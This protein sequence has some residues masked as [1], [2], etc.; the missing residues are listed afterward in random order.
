MEHINKVT[1]VSLKELL[2]ND[3]KVVLSCSNPNISEEV[4]TK[5]INSKKFLGWVERLDLKNHTLK[6]IDIRDVY[7][8]GQ[9]V[10]FICVD[11]V[12]YPIKVPEGHTPQKLPGYVFIRGDAVAVLVIVIEK[13]TNKRYVLLVNQY[14]LPFGTYLKEFP[15]GMM[16]ENKNFKGQAALELK[17]EAGIEIKPEDLKELLTMGPSLGGCD[18]TVK[19]FYCEIYK[20]QEEI[21]QIESKIYGIHEEGEI[22]KVEIVEFDVQKILS[23]NKVQASATIAALFAYQNLVQHKL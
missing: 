20:S 6:S 17:E 13:E 3:E 5:A 12:V 2:V 21:K 9:A 23:L 16:D 1:V 10:G 22:I 4:L 11:C 19:V 18:E 14:R 8:F 7:M 15:A